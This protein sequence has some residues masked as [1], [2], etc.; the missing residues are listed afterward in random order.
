MARPTYGNKPRNKRIAFYTDEDVAYELQRLAKQT[1]RTVS[2]YCHLL[3]L[4]HIFL[5]AEEE[6]TSDLG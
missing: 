5:I 2:D 3:I 6:F 1:N 4:D